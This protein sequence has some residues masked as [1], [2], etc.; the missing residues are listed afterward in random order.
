MSQSNI[1]AL[2]EALEDMVRLAE[3]A[4]YRVE[5]GAFKEE[6]LARIKRACPALAKARTV[7]MP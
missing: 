5:P 2:V 1:L 3:G 6:G 4:M 7:E